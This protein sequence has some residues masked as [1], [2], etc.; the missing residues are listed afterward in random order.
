LANTINFLYLPTG[1]YIRYD[2]ELN[3]HYPYTKQLSTFTVSPTT[4]F[5]GTLTLNQVFNEKHELAFLLDKNVL[6][7]GTP[8][9]SGSGYLTINIK[10]TNGAVLYKTTT[11]SLYDLFYSGL[12]TWR[13]NLANGTYLLEVITSTGT[14]VFTSYPVIIQC[15][16]KFIDAQNTKVP[17]GGARLAS[18]SRYGPDGKWVSMEWYKYVTESG[19]SSGFLGDI[20]RYDYPF[21]EVVNY[22]GTTTTDYTAISS[23]PVS[24]MNYTQGSPVGYSRVEVRE[25]GDVL[26]NGKTVYEFT[27]LKD[28]NSNVLTSAFPYTPQNTR[29]WGLG[30]P[31]RVS[32]YDS[33]GNLLKRTVNTYQYDTTAFVNSNFKSVKLGHAKTIYDGDPNVN[34]TSKTRTFVGEDYYPET[35]RIYLV[36]SADTMYYLNGSF[37]ASLKTFAYDSNY[38]VTKIISNYDRARGLS[39]EQRMYYPYNYTI[40]GGVGKLRDSQVLNLPVASESW[41]TGDA[42]PRIIAGT[43]T[44]FRQLTSGNV[45][46]DTTFALQANKPVLQS[47]IGVFDSSLL[48]RN[49][50]YFKPQSYF[51]NYDTKGSLTETKNLLSGQS[52]SVLLDYGNQY[53]VANVSNAKTADIAYTS[54][55]AD[56]TGNWTIG[57]AQRDT[58]TGLT[59]RRSYNLNSGNLSKS[60]LSTINTYLLTLWAT[61][62]ASV[63]VNGSLLSTAVASQNGWSLYQVTLSAISSITISG[64]GVIDEVRLHPKDANM[65]TYTYEP[66]IGVTSMADANNTVTYQ[67]YD[68]SSR[69]KL[70]RNK[71]KN[72][73]KRFDYS[74]T[75]MTVDVNPK[76]VA[77]GTVCSPD[78]NG[79]LDSLFRDVNPYSDSTGYIK[80]VF[81]KLECSCPGADA[82]PQL[83]TINGVCEVGSWICV[84]S[85]FRKVLVNGTLQGR[86]ICTY[87]YCFSNGE[88]STYYEETIGTSSCPTFSCFQN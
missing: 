28:I 9:I 75:T 29:S 80:R 17:V 83:K 51:S 74:D 16:N 20:P 6:R 84:S 86:W 15:E 34:S 2:Y 50:T 76:W 40:G 23:Q 58:T 27:D 45:K 77:I 25:V 54:F 57:G 73:I 7:T 8:P 79:H 55:E 87:R 4:T 33:S 5:Q 21:R 63:N 68:P 11:V 52:N 64:T 14:S 70:V 36:S 32:V 69:I 72:I 10:S 26:N 65:I 22:N 60:G 35:G 1:G 67:E 37:T 66:M 42:N 3:D 88:S 56:G 39:L 61:A 78:N 30:L 53:P 38:N 85:V 82:Y 49:A 31:K 12:K 48:N 41:V 13:F 19:Q 81:Q 46:P 44:G 18:V 43:I 71:D 62:G 59:G 24:T 47:L